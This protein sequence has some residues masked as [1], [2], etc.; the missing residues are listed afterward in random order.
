MTALN[1]WQDGRNAYILTDTAIYGP[2]GE[3]KGLHDK[4]VVLDGMIG[5]CRIALAGTGHVHAAVLA[6]ALNE[7]VNFDARD[8][9]MALPDIVKAI[10]RERAILWGDDEACEIGI[11]AAVY[12]PAIPNP[13]LFMI[14]NETGGFVLDQRPHELLQ[15]RYWTTGQ[16]PFGPFVYD[17]PT[18]SHTITG[19]D[20]HTDGLAMIEA[21]RR[22][23]KLF[24]DGC[25]I[26]GSAAL[27]TIGPDGIFR[28]VL[29][30]WGDDIGAAIQPGRTRDL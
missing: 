26:G 1:I 7:R 19:F 20:P 22:N 24:G 9:L 21:Q 27:V 25:Y 2:A 4:V 13:A 18:A 15:I 14:S 8:T 23:E 12:D 6:A 17:D 29:R 28:H 3:V 16:E 5:G 30:D 11:V 10:E